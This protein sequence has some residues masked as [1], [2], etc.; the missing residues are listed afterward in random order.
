M[1]CQLQVLKNES[2]CF[3]FDYD[4]NGSGDD[5]LMMKIILKM[6]NIKRKRNN[7]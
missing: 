4:G 1:L 7:P 3:D 5:N 2:K 6:M